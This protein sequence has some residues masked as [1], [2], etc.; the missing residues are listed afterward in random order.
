MWL[1]K[2][3]KT[4]ESTLLKQHSFL[5]HSLCVVP[6]WLLALYLTCLPRHQQSPSIP[7]DW[8]P[9]VFFPRA[10]RSGAEIAAASQ[11]LGMLSSSLTL[12]LFLS[13]VCRRPYSPGALSAD[14][15]S[16]DY[17]CSRVAI[18]RGMTQHVGMGADGGLFESTV[19]GLDGESCC[20]Q[21]E[22]PHWHN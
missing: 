1:K 17:T 9:S 20:V 14:L 12:A 19:M 13:P 6:L 4:L 2:L 8:A 16:V 7:C 3:Q 21:W 11:S 15:E 18:I 22:W 10:V 5:L